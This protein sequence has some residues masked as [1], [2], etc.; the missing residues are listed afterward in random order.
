MYIKVHPGQTRNCKAIASNGLTEL[1]IWKRQKA[2]QDK[3][4]LIEE[5]YRQIGQLKVE[6]DWLKKSGINI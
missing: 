6:L 1:F 3:D 5:L 2:E 4:E